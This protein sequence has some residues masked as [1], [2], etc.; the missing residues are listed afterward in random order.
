MAF[1]QGVPRHD[2]ELR[3]ENVAMPNQS[4]SSCAERGC[5][6][7]DSG[8]K[9]DVLEG[10]A[11]S[12]KSLP[13]KHF[14]DQR[15]SELFDQICELPEY[16]PTRTELA[17]MREHADEI[18][19][20]IGPGVALVEYGSGS[21]VKTRLLLDA[22]PEPVAYVPVDIS[23][24]HLNAAAER[25]A[26][27]YPAIDVVPVAADFTKS[28]SL[29]SLP[30]EASHAAVYFPGSTIGN[31]LPKDAAH[32][33]TQIASLV[34]TGGGLVIGIDLKKDTA[35]LEAAYNDAA[36]VTAEFNKNLLKRINREL[37][38]DV[39]VEGFEHRAVYDDD[40]GRISISLVAEEQQSVVIAGEAIDFAAGE[41]IHTEY[42]HKYTVEGF[43]EL[44]ATAG[45]QLR[46]AWTDPQQWFAVLHLVVVADVVEG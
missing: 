15:G 9:S 29:P 45:L 3:Q 11:Q 31:F 38:A 46:K 12:P 13:C 27:A 37:D 43:A 7:D 35:V 39:A 44:A 10:L 36:G 2:N 40:A 4:T 21:S 14:Y 25:L 22:L 34:G 33:L 17:I 23:E 8:F 28:L 19:A 41:A 30:R 5:D 16:Y 1:G 26:S 20:A 42:S 24:E 32:L 6:E 18:A